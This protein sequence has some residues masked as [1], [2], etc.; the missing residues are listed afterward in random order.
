MALIIGLTSGPSSQRRE[1]EPPTPKTSAIDNDRVQEYRARIEEQMRK[2]ALERE[3]LARAK[4]SIESPDDRP[5]APTTSPSSPLNRGTDA[6]AGGASSAPRERSWID[7]D[8]EK[9]EYES[10]YASNVA[11]SRRT[12]LT[13]N[14]TA[15]ATEQTPTDS[16]S[17]P[18]PQSASQADLARADGPLYRVLEGTLIETVL[19]HRLDGAFSG[20][21]DCLVTTPVY[22]H[23][24][25]RL[26]IP[27]GTRVL[28]EV[29]K[30]ETFGDQRLAVLF[31]R[32]IM[33]DGYSANLDKLQGL[34][35]I[36]ETGLVDQINRH[37]LQTFGVSLAI[38]A[39]AGLSQANTRTGSDTPVSDAYRQGVATSLSQ[40]SL[41][42]L[43]RY[44]NILPTFTIREGHRVKVYLTGDLL[45]P[46]YDHHRMPED[47]SKGE[48]P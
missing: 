5:P 6:L 38:G 12:A 40:S 35:Q 36:G 46:A 45:L 21:V 29:K 11:F 14:R 23:D 15:V 8:R 13:A 10:R 7:L 2:L 16:P 31:H 30:V 41:H 32:L 42:I 43:D 22:S 27:Q 9:R 17:K 25:R 47:L 39:I 1:T 4:E 3:R 28:G 34:N 26:L 20:P 37:Y 18:N 24:L 44:L 19:T 48:R 33:P